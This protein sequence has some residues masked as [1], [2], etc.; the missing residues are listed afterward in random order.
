MKAFPSL[1]GLASCWKDY[2]G[3][4]KISI[5]FKSAD[6]GRKIVSYLETLP[7]YG[8]EPHVSWYSS[9]HTFFLVTVLDIVFG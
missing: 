3:Y 8:N 1:L 5:D 7:S 4:Q 6:V 9:D 2:S